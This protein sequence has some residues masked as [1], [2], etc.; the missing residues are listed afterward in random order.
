M[1]GSHISLMNSDVTV[2]MLD[3]VPKLKPGVIVH[4]HDIHLP[5][6]YPD[7]FVKWYWN[8]QYIVAAYLL[9]AADR[10]KI[11]MPSRYAGE[12]SSSPSF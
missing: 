2:F 4:I 9:G 3:V 12:M 6:D 7:M 5:H 10:I 11:L 1:D 8:E